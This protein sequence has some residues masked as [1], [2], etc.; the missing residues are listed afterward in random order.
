M[1]VGPANDG[2]V[3]EGRLIE[4]AD[5]AGELLEGPVFEGRLDEG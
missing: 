1:I 4:G 5:A 2:P 3:F